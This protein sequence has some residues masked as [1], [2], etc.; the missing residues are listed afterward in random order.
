[1]SVNLYEYNWFCLF[2]EGETQIVHRRPD[3]HAGGRE[4]YSVP[5]SRTCRN[6]MMLSWAQPSYIV[7]IISLWWTLH[8]CINSLNINYCAALHFFIQEYR[9]QP[10]PHHLTLHPLPFHHLNSLLLV[11]TLALASLLPSNICTHQNNG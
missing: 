2:P 6:S 4:Q 1:M 7:V 10:F 8:V 5:T 9:I 11:F 3:Y